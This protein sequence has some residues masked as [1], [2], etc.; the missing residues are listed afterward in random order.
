MWE[1]RERQPCFD[2]WTSNKL[3]LTHL[4]TTIILLIKRNAHSSYFY[5]EQ[6]VGWIWMSNGVTNPTICSFCIISGGKRKLMCNIN[7]LT[8]FMSIG[9]FPFYHLKK[10]DL[11][12]LIIVVTWVWFNTSVVTCGNQQKDLRNTYGNQQQEQAWSLFTSSL[13]DYWRDLADTFT[14]P[15]YQKRTKIKITFYSYQLDGN[16]CHKAVYHWRNLVSGMILF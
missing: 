15:H 6:A 16:K 9:Y 5:G 13:T 12:V 10:K 7:L 11:L 1:V 3:T 4:V 14:S 2:L 8:I